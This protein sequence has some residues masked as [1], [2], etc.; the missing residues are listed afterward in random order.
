MRDHFYQLIDILAGEL[1]DGLQL[2]ATLSGEESDFVR[3]NHARVRQAGHVSQHGLQ[4]ALVAGRRHA[5]GDCELSGDPNADLMAG[6]AL[7]A[8]LQDLLDSC[9][10]D[11][12]LNYNEQPSSSEDVRGEPLPVL[13]KV[14]ETISRAAKG[15]DLVGVYA[16]GDL[17]RGYA[18]SLGQKNWLARSIFNLD[19]SCHTPAH[20]AVKSYYAGSR[21]CDE[22]L[23]RHIDSQRQ[24]LAILQKP[25][26]QLAPGNYRAYL[27]PSALAELLQLLGYEGF[28]LRELRTCQ[29]PLLKLAQGS[30]HFNPAVS[31]HDDRGA[32]YEPLFSDEGF[33]LPASVPLIDN[34]EFADALADARSAREYGE[35][36]NAADEVPDS[37]AMLPG[38]LAN[39]DIL[40]ALDTGLYI[41]HLWYANFSDSNNCRMTGMTRYACYWVENGQIQAPLA[42][43][44]FDDSLYRLLGDHLEAITRERQ[45]MHSADSYGER[46]LASMHLPGILCSELKLTL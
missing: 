24:A 16:A 7:L 19:W 20:Q 22:T 34:G 9:P 39:G 36:V 45:F 26:K 32:A 44:R 12:Y 14:I 8:E 6:R 41:N 31:M 38:D 35:S 18:N 17:V 46:S 13:G 37:L 1:A 43:M 28:S 27:A 10:E 11:P 25:A 30:R 42:V 15:L 3:F 5:S 40:T 23:H 21:W 29:S 4:L 2:H 33:I